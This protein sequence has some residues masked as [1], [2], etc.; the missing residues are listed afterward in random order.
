MASA[1]FP[2]PFPSFPSFLS[3]IFPLLTFPAFLSPSFPLPPFS[4]PLPF[5]AFLSVFYHSPSSLSLCSFL[6]MPS[7]LVRFFF[8][9][10][11][12]FLFFPPKSNKRH[13][14]SLWV[15]PSRYASYNSFSFFFLG[16]GG[17]RV[18]SSSSF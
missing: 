14:D 7:L 18:S 17:I 6:P 8:E 5:L 12:P 13:P 16:A 3:P 9:Q 11:P 2:L 15:F 1:L 4:F 10:S